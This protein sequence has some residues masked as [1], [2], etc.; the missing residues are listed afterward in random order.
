METSATIS[1]LST[2][3]MRRL[4]QHSD[5]SVTII[6]L[7]DNTITFTAHGRE[8][9]EHILRETGAAMVYSDYLTPDKD[10]DS[11]TLHRLI[12]YQEGALRDDFDFGHI[13]LV[14]TAMLREAV[15]GMTE[16]Y[17]AA[18]W[19]DLRLRL[20]RLGKIIH[21]MEPLY[22]SAPKATAD[23]SD[24]EAQFSYVDP[25]N[26]LSQIEM[27]RAATAHLRAVGA[28]VDPTA[29]RT[30]NTRAGQ[31]PVEAS[32]IIPVRNRCRTIA[33]AVN[34]ALTQKA[35]FDFNV[36]V[37]D[38]R[39]DDGT[40]EILADI[41]AGEPRLK[42]IDTSLMPGPAPGIGGCWNLG[43][44]SRHCGR[45]AV[46]LDSDDIYSRPDTLQLIVDKFHERGCAMVIGSYSLTDFNGNPLPPGLIDHAE[47]TD[48]NGPNNALRINGLGAPRAFFT[49]I[50][51][52]INFPDVSYGE[53]Y[54]MG[55]AISRKY[56]IGRIYQ[57]LYSCRRWEGN[58][59]HALSEER[60]NANNLYKDRIRT[61]E[62]LARIEA[63]R[64]EA[65]RRD[66][67]ASHELGSGRLTEFFKSQL[68][69]WDLTMAN[70][71][72][73]RL[74]RPTPLPS[75]GKWHLAKMLANHRR[76]S[77]TARTD[78]GSIAARPCFLC[79][80]NR[81]ASQ[82]SLTWRGYEVL[83]NPYP[84]APMHF[85]IASRAHAPQLISGNRITDMAALARAGEGLFVFY[86]GPRAGA[87]AP[88]HFHFQ[89]FAPCSLAGNFYHSEGMVPLTSDGDATLYGCDRGAA[90][91][92]CFVIESGA[93]DSSLKRLFIRLQ[94]AMTCAAPA[95]SDPEPMVN[96]IMRVNP[97]R[98]DSIRTLI[99]PRSKHRPACY[100]AS[101]NPLLVS[102]ATIEMLGTI[103]CSRQDD[104]DRIDTPTAAA[105]LSEVGIS[106]DIFNRI[107]SGLK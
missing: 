40:S 35:D 62:L 44:H 103:V 32:V 54:A 10:T 24:G 89:A 63:N 81:P 68:L 26:R 42:I 13:A 30:V 76:A 20:S 15:A 105:I 7:A 4:A 69:T 50:A 51:R 72:T 2:E 91:Y 8:R 83:V 48:G 37:V 92:P 106:T 1:R 75:D 53:D 86:N 95:D 18:G 64:S 34:S 17:E 45:F 55:L 29:F 11:H 73:I 25:R 71:A 78:A 66:M 31:F 27:E 16:D 79:Q 23:G 14:N 39:S 100:S 3:A 5:G 61:I 77:I 85:T 12:D 21:I 58:S 65:M 38:N 60:V 98:P 67:A 57:S 88:D 84:L 102:P 33:D 41:A 47:W 46:Q 74:D 9:M 80:S 107:I 56:P 82:K 101:S 97:E 96:I 49:P 52:E 93:D 87:S 59:D 43:I 70:Y 28:Y 104:F 22:S 94:D 6:P 36:I 19:Y 90:P 99:I